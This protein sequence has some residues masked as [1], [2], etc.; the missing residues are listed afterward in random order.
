MT[1]LD[2]GVYREKMKSGT[3]K[4]RLIFKVFSTCKINYKLC[5]S[6]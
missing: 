5:L 1:T 2:K 3:E 4:G 6:K